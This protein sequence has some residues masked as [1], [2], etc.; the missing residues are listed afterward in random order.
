MNVLVGDDPGDLVTA[1]VNDAFDT[2]LDSGEDNIGRENDFVPF[3]E[4]GSGRKRWRT[5]IGGGREA[6]LFPTPPWGNT[7][8][9]RRRTL[10]FRSLFSADSFLDQAVDDLDGL[11]TDVHSF[12]TN[13]VSLGQSRAGPWVADNEPSVRRG[14]AGRGRTRSQT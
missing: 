12:A 8:S 4:C 11:G 1:S 5:R 10:R 3:P 6:P 13:H 7:A 2:F 14:R 9:A